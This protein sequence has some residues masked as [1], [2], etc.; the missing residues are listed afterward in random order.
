MQCES[1]GNVIVLRWDASVT[2]LEA[3]ERSIYHLADRVTG[4]IASVNETWVTTLY[5]VDPNADQELVIED[6]RR[7]IN[8]QSLKVRIEERT[9]GIRNLIFALAFSKTDLAEQVSEE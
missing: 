6:F 7:E 9:S 5:M 1:V 2:S 4:T 8:N 3:I